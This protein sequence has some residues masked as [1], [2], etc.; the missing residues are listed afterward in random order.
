MNKSIRD[1]YAAARTATARALDALIL[2]EMQC[3]DSVK[4]RAHLR[5]A[6]RSAE[7]ARKTILKEEHDADSTSPSE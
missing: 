4:A 1:Y 6:V 5:Q 2:L 3:G 7:D